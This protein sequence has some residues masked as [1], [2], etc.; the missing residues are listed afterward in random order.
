MSL[1]EKINRLEKENAEIKRQLYRVWRMYHPLLQ[2]L[3]D[4][5]YNRKDLWGYLDEINKKIE[6]SS[7]EKEAFIR[8][9]RKMTKKLERDDS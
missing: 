1:E 8:F 2:E 4:E 7:K 6:K 3:R 5:C 9:L